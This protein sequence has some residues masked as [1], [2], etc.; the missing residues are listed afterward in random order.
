M[1]NLIALYVYLHFVLPREKNKILQ[2]VS[3]VWNCD[4][5]LNIILY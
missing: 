2:T 4:Q 5:F 1:I 3:F